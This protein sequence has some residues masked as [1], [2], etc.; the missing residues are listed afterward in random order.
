MGVVSSA[1]AVLFEGS[2]LKLAPDP[3]RFIKGTK[4]PVTLAGRVLVK[5]NNENGSIRPGDYLTSS[6]VPGIAMKATETGPTIGIA[7]ESFNG[8]AQGKVLVFINVGENKIR[9]L[10]DEVEKIKD[11]NT[12]IQKRLDR[13]ERGYRKT[14]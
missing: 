1:P 14:Y 2:E 12:A 7:M 3:D 8:T 9:A 13:L 11:S 5:V 6:S 10:V 4:P